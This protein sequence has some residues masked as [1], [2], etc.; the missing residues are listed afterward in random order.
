[1]LLIGLPVAMSSWTM[2]AWSEPSQLLAPQR[3]IAQISPCGPRS[4]P[5]LEPQGGPEGGVAH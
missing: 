5:A 4:M 3:S 2:G 1:M